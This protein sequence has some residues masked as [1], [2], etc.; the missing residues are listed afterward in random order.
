MAL[1][2]PPSPSPSTGVT[3]LGAANAGILNN[4]AA[5]A[6]RASLPVL[7]LAGLGVMVALL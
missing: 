6:R 5:T 3:P 7:A 2:L 4:S 1:P